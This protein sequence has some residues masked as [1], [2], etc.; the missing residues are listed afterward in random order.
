MGKFRQGSQRAAYTAFAA[1][2]AV[3]ET[4]SYNF[5]RNEFN[6]WWK[7][8]MVLVAMYKVPETISKSDVYAVSLNPNVSLK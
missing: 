3:L 1:K 5:Q 6:L 7:I 2:F 8:S 4:K